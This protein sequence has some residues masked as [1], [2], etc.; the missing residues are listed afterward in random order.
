MSSF[1]APMVSGAVTVGMYFAGHLSKDIYA[2][3]QKAEL[4]ALQYAGEGRSTTLLPNLDRLNF[5]LAGHLRDRPPRFPTLVPHMIYA[6]AY[7]GALLGAGGD[8]SSSAA[9]SSSRPLAQSSRSDI[10]CLAR[11]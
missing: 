11:R 9:T 7:S 3:G 6:M 4:G 8:S 2:L 5:R 1:A 10:P